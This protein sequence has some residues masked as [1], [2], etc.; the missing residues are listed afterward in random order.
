M[1][2][3]ILAIFLQVISFNAL[4][5]QADLI[6]ISMVMKKKD[7]LSYEHVRAIVSIKNNGA[8]D[9]RLHNQDGVNWLEFE[10][11]RNSVHEV[12]MGKKALFADAIIPAGG[13]IKREVVLTTIYPLVS[14]GNYTIRA[15]VNP[16]GENLFKKR[17]SPSFFNVL[18]G[19]PIFSKQTGL[20]GG[21]AIEYRVINLNLLEAD[22]LYFQS[23]NVKTKRIIHTFSL[24]TYT[25]VSKPSFL[26]DD[27]SNLNAIFQVSVDKFRF[28]TINPKGE[29]VAQ[30]IHK[31]TTKGKPF[32][33]KNTKN[34]T[35]IVRNSS[36]FNLVEEKQKKLSVHDMSQ[37]PPFAY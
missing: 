29:I 2:K 13:T 20:Q 24:G 10:I 32:M 6:D 25:R 11:T 31:A 7:Y 8:S 12:K 34:G 28:L 1:K 3:L 18:N 33:A 15:R 36:V 26:I 5:A 9:L 37:R 14:Q 23:Y 16:P 22:Q 21:N 17:S 19:V 30:E 27:L 35:V 4:F